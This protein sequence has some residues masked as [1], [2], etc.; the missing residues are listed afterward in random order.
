VLVGRVNEPS[1]PKGNNAEL[2][3]IGELYYKI[4]TKITNQI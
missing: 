3:T 2:A 4:K 1:F